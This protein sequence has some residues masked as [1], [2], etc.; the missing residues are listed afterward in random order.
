MFAAPVVMAEKQ[1]QSRFVIRPFLAEDVCQSRHDMMSPLRGFEKL[2]GHW[3]GG[4]RTPAT[5][6]RHF[7]AGDS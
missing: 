5:R 1:G 2:I 3:S 7:V 6:R 4:L